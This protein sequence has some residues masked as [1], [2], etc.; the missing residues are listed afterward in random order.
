MATEIRADKGQVVEFAAGNGELVRPGTVL[1]YDPDDE[2][3][4]GE[5]SATGI[6]RWGIN[7][8]DSVSAGDVIGTIEP[9]GEGEEEEG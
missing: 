6:L 1:Y 3:A 7:S 2:S 8:G 5:A 4:K 9:V